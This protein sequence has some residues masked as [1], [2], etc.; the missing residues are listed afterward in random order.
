[1]VLSPEYL[2][3]KSGQY[4]VVVPIAFYSAVKEQLVQ[5][6]YRK[7]IELLS[8]SQLLPHYEDICWFHKIELL[9]QFLS[10][11]ETPK[12]QILNL[13]NFQ[14][15]YFHVHLHHICLYNEAK[16]I[17]EDGVELRENQI[18]MNQFSKVAIARKAD[19]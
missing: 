10:Q 15:S 18:T 12:T 11:T 1:M 19:V 17:I 3:G 6:G 14:L 2:D 16:I 9:L 5:G 4:Y 7:D 8:Q 13:D